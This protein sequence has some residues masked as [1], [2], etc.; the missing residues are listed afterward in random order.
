MTDTERSTP[1]AWLRPATEY[2]PLVLFFVTYKL[3]GLIWATGAF[4][5]AIAIAMLV[6]WRA[7]RR[8]PPMTVF[9]GIVVLLFGGLTLLTKDPIFIKVKPTIVSGLIGLVLIGGRL[10]G[11]PLL[12][13]LLASA[14][15]MDDVGWRA[16]SLRF[17]LLSIAL[18]G[19]NELVWRTQSEDFWVNFKLF[20]LTGITFVFMLAQSPMLAR[21]ALPEEEA[22]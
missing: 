10:A 22:G 6:A 21:H 18:A 16:L 3:K 4:M 9:T 5:G 15:R 8:V 12:K 14:L 7:E 20:G 2:G 13:P 11:R 1:P 19:L 17:G